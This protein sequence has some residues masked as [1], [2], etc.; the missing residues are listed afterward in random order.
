MRSKDNLFHLIKAMSKS[1]KRYFVLDAKKSGRDASRYL[2]LFESL[3]GMEDLDEEKL[4]AKFAKNLSSDKAYL[5]EA[6]LRSMRDYRSP[7]SKA[8]QVKERL[9][10]ARFLYERGLYDQST[11]RIMEAKAMARELED[12]FT[13]LEINKEEQVSLFD[14][15]AKVE[16]EHIEKLDRERESNLEA[17]EEELK[18]LNLHYR[19]LLEVFR[20]FNLKDENSIR[21]LKKRLPIELLTEENK[22]KSPQALRRYFLCN[23][24]YFN[25]IGERR[26]VYHYFLETAKWWDGYGAFKEEEFYRY[27][28]DVSNLVNICN[29]IE[30]YFPVG[31]QWLEK[32]KHEESGTSFHNQKNIFLRLSIANLL[33]LLNQGEFDQAHK[34]LPEI[35][36]GLNKFGLKKSIPLVGNITTVY[37]LV[38]D[39]KNCIKW[40]SH[41]IESM[42]TSGRE[43]IQRVIRLYKVIA[44]FE[45]DELEAAEADIRSTQRFYKQLGLKKE[46]FEN[47]VLNVFVKKIFNAPLSEVKATL[48]DFK[49]Y[50]DEVKSRPKAGNLLGVEELSIW[51]ER[52]LRR[53]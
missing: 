15:R 48:V 31:K 53:G 38:G 19:L 18:Y 4:K 51:A 26:K 46:E 5:Y 42:K 14:R 2:S 41:I 33:H 23:A 28:N 10:D 3:S 35:I 6:I 36:D 27:I 32:L 7:S 21:E 43:D 13:L 44:N 29:Q 37:F 1:E 39:Y 8:A 12:Q 30:E 25:L 49:K 50:L 40:A 47:E 34:L 22:P 11:Q 20:E 9:M 52:K 17:I 16:L 24:A 45:L